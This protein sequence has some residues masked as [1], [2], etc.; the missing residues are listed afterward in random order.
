VTK[1]EKEIREV[2]AD[3]RRVY[4][5]TTKTDF[6]E[7]FDILS[8]SDIVY[9]VGCGSSYNFGVSASRF[10]TLRTG[11]ETKPIPGGEITFEFAENVGGGR[12]KRSAVLISRSG[13]STEV[14]RAGKELK[15]MGIPTIGVTIESDSSLV[16]L[17]DVS[18]IPPVEEESL[19]MTKSF[20]LLLMSFE[21]L[22]DRMVGKNVEIYGQLIERMGLV[23]QRSFEIVEM[24]DLMEYEH[25]VFLGTGI[26]EG[27]AREGALKLEEMSLSKVEA[28]STYE[29]RHGPKALVENGVLIIMYVRGEREEEKLKDE[30][31]RYGGKVIAVGLKRDVETSEIVPE[32]IFMRPTFAQVLGLKIAERKGL[33][34]ENP[35]NLTKVVKLE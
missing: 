26:Y 17:A 6:R 9:F 23:L 5:Y 19:V 10:L 29:Y 32:E 28:Y 8:N 1:V 24:E 30:L 34:V 12:L 4:D 7:M 33:D 31:T 2:V 11:V 18:L 13:E 35:R 3:A 25:Y 14:I 20:N 22:V 16:Q 21:I 27:I 15:K